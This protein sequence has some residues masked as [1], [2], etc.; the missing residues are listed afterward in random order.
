MTVFRNLASSVIVRML[1]RRGFRRCT[2]RGKF[3][4]RCPRIRAATPCSYRHCLHMQCGL[5][6]R[7][8][9]LSV[10][11]VLALAA[12]SEEALVLVP[13]RRLITTCAGPYWQIDPCVFLR[14]LQDRLH[15]LCR[16][17]RL[18]LALTAV[19]RRDHRLE[20]ASRLAL[21]LQRIH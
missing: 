10:V 4:Y 11:S 6:H 19:Q 1:A 17:R 14:M 21:R 12:R 9:L 7:Q 20:R 15:L 8:R 3:R 13:T 18:L 16:H 2:V 5:H